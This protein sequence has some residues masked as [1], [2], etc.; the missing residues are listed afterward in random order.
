[1]QEI[2]EKTARETELL[3]T[4]ASL[5]DL[6]EKKTKIYSRLLTEPSLAQEMEMLSARHQQRKELLFTMT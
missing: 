6:G 4:L 5:E 2:Q 1:M 3:Q